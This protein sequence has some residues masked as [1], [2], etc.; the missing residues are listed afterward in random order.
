MLLKKRPNWFP[1]HLWLRLMRQRDKRKHYRRQ[2][3][4]F[5]KSPSL[6]IAYTRYRAAIEQANWQLVKQRIFELIKI[7]RRVGDKRVILDMVHALD[8]VGCH[9]ES[10]RLW[11]ED[12]ARYEDRFPN[13]WQGEDL[14]TKSVLVFLDQS[15][16]G[17][18]GI[19]YRCAPI[20]PKIIAVAKKVTVIVEPRLLKIFRHNFP[21]ANIFSSGEEKKIGQIEYVISPA[22]L[23]ARFALK[24]DLPDADF[25]PLLSDRTKTMEMRKKYLARYGDKKPLIGICWHSSH[26]GKELPP[27]NEWHD[28]I[29]ATDAVFFSL[30]YGNIAADIEKLGSGRVVIDESIN[31]L[32]D[33]DDFAA[34]I[35]A[36]DGVITIMNTLVHVGGSLGVPTVVLRDDWFRR[37]LPFLSDRLPWYPYLRVVGKNGREWKPIFDEAYAKLKQLW[38]HPKL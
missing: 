34:Q 31:Q 36:L 35:S 9:R 29:H 6:A 19:G 22:N 32:V 16:G 7:A 13:E 18:L 2:A 5:F 8:R 3:I 4:R 24:N 10:G 28:F 37:D 30:Q 23:L 20:I 21:E 33:M 12:L 15:A 25:R 27:L 38:I 1:A 11:I 14:S 26:H 17:G